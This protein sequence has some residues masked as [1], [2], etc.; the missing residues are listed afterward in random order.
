MKKL[1]FVLII[2]VLFLLPSCGGIFTAAIGNE[3]SSGTC[4]TNITWTLNRYGLLTISGTG[5]IPQNYYSELSWSGSSKIKS[6]SITS[7]V[8]RIGAYAFFDCNK[9]KN[10]SI[11]DTVTCIDSYAFGNC[12]NI[13]SITIPSSVT[14]IGSS[15]FFICHGLTSI[16]VDTANTEYQDIN[17]VLFTKDGTT[18]KCYPAGKVDA[19]YI[20]PSTVTTIQDQAFTACEKLT[21][22]TIPDSVIEIGWNALA[23]CRNLTSITIPKSVI[24]IGDLQFTGCSGLTNITVDTANTKYQD[25]DGVLFTKDGTT[26]MCYPGGKVDATYVIPSTVTT[27]QEYAFSACEN[28]TSITFSDTTAWY[29]KESS[30]TNEEDAIAVNV[31]N[32]STNLTYFT[33]TYDD[34]YWYKME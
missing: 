25:I 10:V 15:L 20:I 9:L 8:T 12:E 30:W 22:I 3:I 24:S 11:A 14:Y 26:L 5:E 6:V 31:E 33:N 1:C 23:S 17:G 19:T 28:L 7:G 27:I 18:L 29:V 21:S 16:A 32:S 4:G 34:Y 2:C 13:T